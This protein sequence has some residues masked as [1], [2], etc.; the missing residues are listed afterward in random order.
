MNK[1]KL[2]LYFNI[3]N[4]FQKGWVYKVK[5]NRL[6]LGYPKKISKVFLGVPDNI[7][8]AFIY[9]QEAYF[10]SQG[11]YYKADMVAGKINTHF[12]KTSSPFKNAPKR[13]DGVFSWPNVYTEI[14]S[15]SKYYQASSSSN[16]VCHIHFKLIYFVINTMIIAE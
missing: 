2:L 13:I 16:T 3:S 8:S 9:R 6:S 14:F 7:N 4:I 10:I 11:V 5:T 1:L 15:G 12:H